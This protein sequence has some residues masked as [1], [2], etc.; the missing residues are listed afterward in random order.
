MRILL[1][2]LLMADNAVMGAAMRE[3]IAGNG[4]AVGWVQRDWV[5][6]LDAGDNAMA[7]VDYGTSTMCCMTT[8]L[9]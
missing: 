6:R 5:Q 1:A 7:G 3:P 2:I 8:R 9:S 4:C